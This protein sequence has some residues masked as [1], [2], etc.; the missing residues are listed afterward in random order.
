MNGIFTAQTAESATHRACE[1]MAILAVLIVAALMFASGAIRE[2]RVQPAA[3]AAARASVSNQLGHVL[4]MRRLR[5]A[6][7]T[8]STV[9]LT[10]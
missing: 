8:P 2:S 3:S 4:P 7:N 6:H 9:R 5:V 1:L 10:Q